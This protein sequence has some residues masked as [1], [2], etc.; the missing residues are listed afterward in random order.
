MTI[1]QMLCLIGV[2]GMI[3]G[4][5]AYFRSEWK[6]MRKESDAQ[7]KGLQALL[8]AQMINDYNKWEDREYAPIYARD[9]FENCWEQYHNL[10][11]NGVMDNL[12]VMFLQL[13]TDP[14]NKHSKEE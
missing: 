12:H 11:V 13:P 2:P 7:K 4:I 14:P 5:F 8:R 9:N 6:K 1:Y 3:A 10:G